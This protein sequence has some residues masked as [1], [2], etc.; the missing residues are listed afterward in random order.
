MIKHNYKHANNPVGFA[1]ANLL[2]VT[3]LQIHSVKHIPK[4]SHSYRMILEAKPFLVTLPLS[5]FSTKPSKINIRLDFGINYKA[6]NSEPSRLS[7]KL[8][9]QKCSAM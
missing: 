4:S 7:Y 1:R 5:K 8:S 3:C 9:E 6:F 2:K